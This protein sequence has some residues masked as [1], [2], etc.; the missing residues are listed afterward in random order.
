[1]MIAAIVAECERHASDTRRD[2]AQKY[3]FLHSVL[4]SFAFRS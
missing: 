4:S 2:D 1:M 3:Q